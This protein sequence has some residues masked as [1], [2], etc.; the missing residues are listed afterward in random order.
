LQHQLHQGQQKTRQPLAKAGSR[1]VAV[2]A[3]F[4]T[5]PQAEQIGVDCNY[6]FAL[7]EITVNRQ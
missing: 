6:I 4:I 7:I 3:G 5:R 1:F 2:L